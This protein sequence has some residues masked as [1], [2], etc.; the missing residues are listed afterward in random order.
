MNDIKE[1]K[2]HVDKLKQLLDDDDDGIGTASWAMFF[3]NEMQ[4]LYDYWGRCVKQK[5]VTVTRAQYMFLTDLW[6]LWGNNGLK[7]SVDGHKFILGIIER[8]DY[9]AKFYKP[10]EELVR[11]VDSIL[12]SEVRRGR[13]DKC[14]KCN[15]S[16][17]NEV[18]TEG[19]W[20]H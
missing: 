4:W 8:G 20:A 13:L 18:S 1:I 15:R 3:G 10:P 14:E 12:A 17:L 11:V 9:D 2:S 19:R 6:M 7:H 16:T 5:K